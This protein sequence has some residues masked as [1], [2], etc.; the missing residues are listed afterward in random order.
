MHILIDGYNLIRQSIDLKRFERHS[1]EAGRKALIE[2][3]S[4]Y[5]KR[6]DHRITVVFDG[7]I[8][9]SAQEERDYLSGIQI[10]YSSRGVKADDVLKRITA[11]TDE[12]ILVVSSDR[13]IISFASRKGKATLSSIE[14]ESIVN[15]QLTDPGDDFPEHKDEEEEESGHPAGKK[16]PA[17]RLPKAKRQAQTKIRKL[18]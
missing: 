14:F 10:I 12:E 17:Y 5:R 2:W 16:G 8:S 18:Y 9:G 1:L 3:L 7:W 15:R 4:R 11:S 6:K 13:E